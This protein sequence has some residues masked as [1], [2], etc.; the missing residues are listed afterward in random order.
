MP[1][2]GTCGNATAAET[3]AMFESAVEGPGMAAAVPPPGATLQ[4]CTCLAATWTCAS[5]A[6]QLCQCPNLRCWV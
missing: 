1:K 3:G 4:G 5:K 6:V 2:L